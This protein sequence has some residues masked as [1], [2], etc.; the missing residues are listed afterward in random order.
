MTDGT[1]AAQVTVLYDGFGVVTSNSNS[2]FT[3][4]YMF[5]GREYDAALGLQNNRIRPYSPSMARFITID[6]SGFGAGDA[7]LY[8]Y[9]GNNST[10]AIDPSG[11][12]DVMVKVAAFI[13]GR[14]GA[15]TGGWLPEPGSFGYA[16][17]HGDQRTFGENFEQSRLRSWLTFDTLDLSKSSGGHQAGFSF[18]RHQNVFL[19]APSFPSTLIVPNVVGMPWINDIPRRTQMTGS[20]T[21]TLQSFN[22]GST[23]APWAG[24]VGDQWMLHIDGAGNYPYSQVGPNIDYA[25][26]LNVIDKGDSLQLV[27]TFQHDAFPNYEVIIDTQSPVMYDTRYD[28]PGFVDLWLDSRTE[29]INVTIPKGE[30]KVGANG[31][32]PAA[33]ALAG[34]E[35]I[36]SPH[37]IAVPGQ[38]LTQ[39]C[40]TLTASGLLAARLPAVSQSS[41]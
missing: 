20:E 25:L 36:P 9:A 6:P 5:T 35:P 40:S 30:K 8:R 32:G 11:L 31:P 17:F 38:I 4:R 39:T 23:S 1:G 33:V 7:D 29:N 21:L 16:Q 27:G 15:A 24:Q 28:G 18:R 41:P 13:P 2:S 12:R 19:V 26:D 34:V 14:L 10:N 37:W 3:D 22:P